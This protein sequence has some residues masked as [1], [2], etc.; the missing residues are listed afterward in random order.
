MLKI[1][2]KTVFDTGFVNTYYEPRSYPLGTGAISPEVKRPGREAHHS[3][4]T[5]AEVK[6]MWIYTSTPPYI[7]MA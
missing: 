3:P 6:K 7:F 4:P 5:I 1:P 2:K